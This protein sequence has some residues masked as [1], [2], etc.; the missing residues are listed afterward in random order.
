MPKSRCRRSTLVAA[1]LAG[2]LIAVL[3]IRL[4]ATAAK[5]ETGW[6]TI[7]ECWTDAALAWTGWLPRPV[8][9]RD[10]SEQAE[11]WLAECDRIL[12]EH[13]DSA[14][15]HMGAAWILDSP[16][17][18][19]SMR[20]AKRTPWA[21]VLP[22][23]GMQLDQDVIDSEYARFR[24]KCRQRCLEAAARAVKLQPDNVTWRRMWAL[25]QFESGMMCT[26]VPEEE[27][28]RSENWLAV[29]D[30]ARQ[31]DGQNALYDYLAADALW[32]QS[33]EIEDD[34]ESGRFTETLNVVDADGLAEVCSRWDEAQRREFLA[35]GESGLTAVADFLAVS[36]V[37]PSEQW[38]AALS[39]TI[40]YRHFL[41][42]RSLLRAQGSISK[43][44]EERGDVQA[45]VETFR[46][47]WRLY[48]QTVAVHETSAFSLQQWVEIPQAIYA[49][50]LRFA[51]DHPDAVSADEIATLGQRELQRQMNGWIVRDANGTRMQALAASSMNDLLVALGSV[52]AALATVMLAAIAAVSALLG[53]LLVRGR[54]RDV[55]VRLAPQLLAWI[56]GLGG[57]AVVLGMAPAGMISQP[58][59]IATAVTTIVL[60]AI[61]CSAA[62]IWRVVRLARS[63]KFRFQ[64][65]SFL[66]V[67][68][69][70]ALVLGLIIILQPL[71]GPY[72]G[73]PSELVNQMWVRPRGWGGLGAD[74]FR[75]AVSLIDGTWEW[76]AIQWFAY[77]G[78]LVGPLT[79][80]LLVAIWGALA[81]RCA[82]KNSSAAAQTPSIRE[83][84]AAV[85]RALVRNGVVA[86]VL[87][88]AAY[89]WV[90]PQIVE[91]TEAEFQA[92]MAYVRDPVAYA[93]V[94]VREVER[95]KSSPDALGAYRDEAQGQLDQ[96][97]EQ[98]EEMLEMQD[99]ETEDGDGQDDLS[100][101]FQIEDDESQNEP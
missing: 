3:A 28:V 10:P 38:S 54:Q 63:G 2:C 93:N 51:T 64:L 17:F 65:R 101:W 16:D 4:A 96:A 55:R 84:A 81:A 39:R 57:S 53:W 90:A 37:S 9:E 97:A 82:A 86:G 34:Y 60:A 23:L 46:R 67:V 15:L 29:L 73:S 6:E 59:Q 95:I 27:R 62:I 68:T 89:L 76:A 61:A 74:Q 92:D 50:F 83:H 1:G 5:T 18:R 22:G 71:W 40:E 21:S 36:D 43:E 32:S 30:A 45:A 47:Q 20:Y 72:V 14:S 66:G 33:V 49:D 88:L 12:A 52:A 69:A 80:M 8:G 77:H 25:L 91:S 35:I 94:V 42:F 56:V 58:K 85:C 48:E 70:I 99:G 26:N 87:C 31:I 100:P 79:A 11:F 75:N 13:P 41:L 7:R 24:E 78:E 44:A 19:F 98:A